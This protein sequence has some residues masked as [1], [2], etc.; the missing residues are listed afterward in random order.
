MGTF[1]GFS[2]PGVS[3]AVSL[4]KQD[5]YMTEHPDGPLALTQKGFSVAETVYERHTFLSELLLRL[6]VDS[7]IAVQ[8]ACK[9][10]HV[11]SRESFEA[12]KQ[13]VSSL[14]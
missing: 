2:K 6:G 13:Y 5:G 7:N 3:R 14:Q 10:E 12:I 1:L 8:D 9:I 11:I 4:L